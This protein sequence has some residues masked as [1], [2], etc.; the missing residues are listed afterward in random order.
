MD[1]ILRDF[2][3]GVR[4][5]VKH[6]GVT[7]FAITA[8][9]LGI[10]ATTTMFSIVYGALIKG[11]PYDDGDRI[12]EVSRT[13]PARHMD[14]MD[15]PLSEYFDYRDAQHSL[16]RM[17]AYDDGTMNVS[18]G[19]SLPERYLGAW[20]TASFFD[21]MH[22]RPL[23]GRTFAAGEDT[24]RGAKVVVIG[25]G[26]WD[27]R[28]GR[29]EAALGRSIRV[30]GEPFTIVGVMPKEFTLPDN[31]DLWLPIQDDPLAKK[32][33]E[34]VGV[35]VIG[36]LAP[37]VSLPR[38]D[39]EMAAIAKTEAVRYKEFDEGLGAT[40]MS[41]VKSEIG[42]QPIKLLW[43][44]LFAVFFV[45][46]IACANV[47]NLLI[48]RA[49]HRS[50]EV[51]IRAAL[52]AT[53]GAV[54]RQFLIEALMLAAAGALLGTGVA[55]F[56]VRIFNTYLVD[57]QPPSW[58]D[59]G[60][61]P[62][63]LA[64]VIAL[65]LIAT[66][67]SGAL[68]AV[69]SSR[70]DINEVLKDESRGSSSLRIG[71]VSR[72]LVV[73][74]LALSCGLLVASGLMIKSVTNL[75]RMDPGFRTANIFTA[76]VGF[77]SA[78]TDTAMQ[79]HFYDL[80]RDRLAALPGVQ[81]ATMTSALPGIGNDEG[82][83][84]IEGASY[85]TAN[86]MPRVRFTS[87][88]PDYFQTFGIAG[89]RGR[90]LDATDRLGG[91]PVVVVNEAFAN[92]YFPG[93]DPIGHRLR[94]GGPQ[95]TFPWMTI[96]GIVPTV[97]TGDTEEPRAPMYYVPLAQHHE[98]FVSMAVRTAS[99]PMSL[100]SPVREIVAQLQPDLPIYRVNSMERAFAQPTW[101][102]RVF[103]AMFMIFGAIAL[104]LASVGLYAVMSFS[105]SRRT[106]EVGIRM[107]LG[108]QGA[109]VLGL[110]FRQGLWQL[111]IG[112]P[113][114]LGLAVIIAS[115]SQVLLFDVRPLDPAIY[116]GVVVVLTLVGLA[117]CFV[118]ARRATR[119]DPIVALHAD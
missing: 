64:F 19:A 13:M 115:G 63:V 62:P 34:Q 69:Q 2:R 44:M 20:T 67:L 31:C 80:L 94:Q 71:F 14:R 105:V 81:G 38:A 49:A 26:L 107:A 45:L 112:I 90:L 100:T 110:I 99:S 28:F 6:P 61:H 52:G 4:S 83:L 78:Y 106:R 30:N 91:N 48:E 59:I 39:A 77:P 70:T 27:R 79:A 24:P 98:R 113:L 85:A 15:M 92:K 72:A 95:S 116:G 93:V 42:P 33:D 109:Q 73:A 89:L 119:V 82:T 16:A 68:P 111:G 117:A 1:A 96:V 50:K 118:P 7:L 22:I 11:L 35:Q 41:Y 76:R 86:D 32:H 56:G 36:T 21:V 65:A 17:A 9:T 60:L 66:L 114:G 53:R 97:Y 23:L 8:L 55:Y 102:I 104:F 25:Y 10:G 87:V 75:Q 51:S 58:I 54:V 88:A 108:A 37:G 57:A 40:A 3:Y 84:A 18:D 46:L 29:S 74:E 12:V 5:L 101:F 47:A 103:G 43:A